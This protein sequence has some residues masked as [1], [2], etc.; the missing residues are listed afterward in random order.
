[1]KQKWM[2]QE[3]RNDAVGDL[4]AAEYKF[5]IVLETYRPQIFRFL[6][7]SLRDEDLA[8]TL[9]QECFLK[10]YRGWL[11]FGDESNG[12]TWLMR[13]AVSL[14]KN[15]WRKRRMQ[16]WRQTRANAEDTDKA[17]EW[18]PRGERSPEEYVL[19]REQVGKA[20]RVVDCLG[21]RER[22]V[23]LLRF[24]EG[25]KLREIALVVDLEVGAVEAHL[26]QALLRV[27]AALK[28]R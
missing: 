1:M 21:E 28:A 11:S 13:I 27:C 25:L 14:Q 26:S 3:R 6:L 24:V 20:W 4:N 7:V 18:L 10:A 22:T 8:E 15:H 2:I 16:F 17:S 12:M 23:F 19:A 9:T 5:S